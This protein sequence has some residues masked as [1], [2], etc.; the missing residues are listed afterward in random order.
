MIRL[1]TEFVIKD[2][3]TAPNVGFADVLL[4]VY[5]DPTASTRYDPGIRI[6]TSGGSAY[7]GA[8]CFHDYLTP[9]GSP[10]DPHG[11]FGPYWDAENTSPADTCGDL[12]DNDGL[13]EKVVG[14]LTVPCIDADNNGT[15]DP[16]QYCAATHNNSSADC[17]SVDNTCPRPA[18]KCSCGTSPLE[19]T[20]RQVD[21]GVTKDGP[22]S[23]LPGDTFQYTI[24]VKNWGPTFASTGFALSDDLDPW[25]QFVS[26][27]DPNTDC[28]TVENPDDLPLGSPYGDTVLCNV[29]DFGTPPVGTLPVNGVY[30]LHMTAQMHPFVPGDPIWGQNP[31]SPLLNTACADGFEAE[32]TDAVYPNCEDASSTT[33]V[34]LAYFSSSFHGNLVHF[35][36]STATEAGNAGFNLYAQTQDG[37]V[38]INDRLIPSNVLDSVEPQTYGYE[39]A[40]IAGGPFFLDEVSVRTET[41]RYGPFSLGESYGT[42]LT[43]ERIDW[44]AI[45]SEHEVKSAARAMDTA[46]KLQATPSAELQVDRDGLY[47]VTYE[48]LLAA[49]ADFY[50]VPASD[51]AVTNRGTP[52]ALRVQSPRSFGPGAYIEFYGQG[53]STL[54]TRTNVYSLVVNRSLAR[55]VAVDKTR[56]PAG[57][58]V[59]SYMETATVERNLKYSFLSPNGDPWYDSRLMVYTTPQSWSFALDVDNYVGGATLPTLDVSLWGASEWTIAPDHHVMLAFNGTPVADELFDGLI[60]HPVSAQL[61][62]GV[63]LDG[64]NSLQITMSGDTGAS[65]DIVNLDGYS[66]TYPRAFVA[67]DGRLS[68]SAAGQLFRVN[69]LPTANV[70]VYRID[71]STVTRLAT[72]KVGGSSGSYRASFAGTQT[73]ATY[74]VS[75]VESLLTPGIAAGRP[76]TDITTGTAGYLVI[77]HPDFV[78]GL[79]PLTMARAAEGYDVRVVDVQ[80]IFAQFGHGIFDPSAIRD[81]VAYAAANMGTQMVVLVGGDTYD[82]LDYLGQ[83][84]ISFIPSL[85]TATDFYSKYAPVDPL[86][87]DLD[88]NGVPDLAIGRLPVRTSAELDMMVTK[89]LAYASKTYGLTAVLAV[90]DG[91]TSDGDA[92]LAGLPEG[93]AVQRA[94]IDEVGLA[95]ARSVLLNAMNGGIALTGYVGHSATSVWTFDGL[96]TAADAAAL[97]NHGMPTVVTQWGC[98]NTYYVAPS[99]DTM[100]HKL[101]LSGDQGATA[102]LGATA[103]SYASSERDLGVLL[104]PKLVQPGL[105]IGVALQQAKSELAA[106]NAAAAD[107]LLGWTILGD[108]A[109]VIQP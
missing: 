36:W 74:L 103:I 37:L 78:E 89:T 76:L 26:E 65:W 5:L 79:E 42:P 60:S 25:L 100:S 13:T 67:T 9:T 16:I 6:S 51:L 28:T 18:S 75:A 20:I 70:V 27:D 85:Y 66:V 50:G 82:Y 77:A 59:P 34:T 97:I 91:F 56:P 80:D 17:T 64:S 41:R 86:Y 104:T 40:G 96:F 88:G 55:R 39:T 11:G 83:G 47:R 58:P 53:L 19:L 15:V 49:G 92:L 95:G 84:S 45:R 10:Y 106:G 72:V 94:F 7:S 57:N 24:Q 90:D 14:P 35:D 69:G 22:A 105:A 107:V 87:T 109:L 32:P 101:L 54:Y 63:L 48:A 12:A 81:Y 33:P 99:Y 102:V 3:D 1:D 8:T 61:P 98:W 62:S 31:P 46:N 93:W 38:R 2:C 71:G 4:R 73:A 30:T 108:P 29:T 68:F 21:L 43:V 44:A 52:V 23:V